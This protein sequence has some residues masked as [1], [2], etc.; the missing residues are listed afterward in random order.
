MNDWPGYATILRQMR[1]IM[2][3]P[4]VKRYRGHYGRVSVKTVEIRG[5]S[6]DVNL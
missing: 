1:R 4:G 2:N 3:V 5:A 6:R